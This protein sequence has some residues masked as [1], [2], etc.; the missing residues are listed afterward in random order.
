MTPA[1]RKESAPV[2]HTGVA[3]TTGRKGIRRGD[4][5][6]TFRLCFWDDETQ[7]EN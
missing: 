3:V 1:G 6:R 4:M 2:A 7:M 5:A